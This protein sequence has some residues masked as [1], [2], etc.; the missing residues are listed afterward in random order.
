MLNRKSRFH[1]FLSFIAALE[2]IVTASAGIAQKADW[3]WMNSNLPPEERADLVLKQ[4][5]LDEKLALLH[6]NGM[7]R[8][9]KWQ[10]PLSE[11]TNGGEG[12]TWR[13]SSVLESL[14]S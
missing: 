3:P 13:V 8:V 9:P 1:F 14:P 10:M 12:Y 7:A 6:G 11:L 2:I 5:T 4:L